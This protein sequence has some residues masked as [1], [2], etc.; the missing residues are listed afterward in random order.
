MFQSPE[1]SSYALECKVAGQ[2]VTVANR[3]DEEIRPILVALGVTPP[4]KILEN[5][6][7]F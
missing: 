6:G 4:T 7:K 2:A 3:V 1:G 5:T